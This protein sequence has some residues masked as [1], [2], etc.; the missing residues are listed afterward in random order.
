[1][2]NLGEC[3]FHLVYGIIVLFV[4]RIIYDEVSK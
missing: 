4:L 2:D 3:V 1:M